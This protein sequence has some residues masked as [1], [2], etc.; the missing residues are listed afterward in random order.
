MKANKSIIL[1]ILFMVCA[2][3]PMLPT[4]N[5]DGK[6]SNSLKVANIDASFNDEWQTGNNW[7]LGEDMSTEMVDVKYSMEFKED[8]NCVYQWVKF[9]YPEVSSSFSPEVAFRFTCTFNDGVGVDWE[10]ETVTDWTEVDLID[11]TLTT[12]SALPSDAALGDMCHSERSFKGFSIYNGSSAELEINREEYGTYSKMVP[13]ET[14]YLGFIEFKSSPIRM[15]EVVLDTEPYT[16]IDGVSSTKSMANFQVEINAT[17]GTASVNMTVPAV[18]TFDLNYTS[19]FTKYKYGVDVNWST[20]RDFPTTFALDEG[21]P[22]CLMANDDLQMTYYEGS[23]TTLYEFEVNT[24][25]DTAN[26]TKDGYTLSLNEFT[27]D[28]TASS[29]ST[30]T[31]MQTNRLYYPK[32]IVNYEDDV[33]RSRVFV[34]Y[35]GFSYNVTERLVYDPTFT[36]F[37]NFE[38]D[39]GLDNWVI[40]IVVTAAI[41][42]V[43]L[44]AI[45]VRSKKRA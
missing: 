1:I 34:F 4:S 39:S 5:E 24:N 13:D 8:M 23:M 33:N 12:D 6:T 17:M 29:A 15:G 9:M 41:L 36:V 10:S 3:I 19:D 37:S 43:G 16:T 14:Q 20:I 35:D 18:L 2:V 28:Y 22:F 11:P 25:K 26:F 30:S 27:T 7:H 32:A 40:P 21:D 38:T 45:I 44:V 42:G 31:D